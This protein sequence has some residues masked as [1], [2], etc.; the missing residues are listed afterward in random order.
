M[1]RR[2]EGLSMRPDDPNTL[3]RQSAGTNDAPRDLTP[4]PHYMESWQTRPTI[5][6]RLHICLRSRASSI[7]PWTE[8]YFLL[9]QEPA[10]HHAIYPP[11][12][13]LSSASAILHNSMVLTWFESLFL[14]WSDLL[15]PCLIWL[16]VSWLDPTHWFLNWFDST[17]LA[18]F[19]SLFLTRFDSLFLPWFDPLV[20]TRFI[21]KE[22]KMKIKHA[23]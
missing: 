22:E 2:S 9:R 3:T 5:R 15:V 4:R 23:N 21:S 13:A 18:W 10:H 1:Y 19:N 20:T 14:T 16:T 12:R 8:N 11:P 6:L 7:S 17:V